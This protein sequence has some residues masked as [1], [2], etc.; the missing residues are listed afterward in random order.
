M[1][2]IFLDAHE[3]IFI[4]YLQK[5]RSIAGAFYAASL[6]GLAEEIRKIQPHLKRKNILFHD[7]NAPSHT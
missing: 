1:A 3:V 7:E 4:D 5:G 6:D 2:S